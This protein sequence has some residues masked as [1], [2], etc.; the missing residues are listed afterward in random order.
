MPSSLSWLV[1]GDRRCILV[2]LVHT[3]CTVLVGCTLIQGYPRFLCGGRPA[4]R[5]RR[6]GT[7]VVPLL[8]PLPTPFAR[9]FSS[10]VL[11][12]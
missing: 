8:V 11:T 12:Q 9:E 4:L 7:A 1:G 5:R 2:G 10:G 3:L 6:R